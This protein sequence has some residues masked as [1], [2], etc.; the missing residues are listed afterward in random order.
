MRGYIHPG[1]DPDFIAIEH[2]DR[3]FAF[4]DGFTCAKKRCYIL[5]H[6]AE[7]EFRMKIHFRKHC[8]VARSK[9]QNCFITV[10]L[11]DGV[12]R[13]LFSNPP[14]DEFEN[15]I[16]PR[17]IACHYFNQGTELRDQRVLW[18]V[19]PVVSRMTR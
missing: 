6:D 12:S 5:K 17:L 1:M 13:S 18:S 7:I 3:G 15:C 2:N 8:R 19:F 14:S 11:Y 10:T 9:N 16:L 4:H